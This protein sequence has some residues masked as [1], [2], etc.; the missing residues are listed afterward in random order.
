MVMEAIIWN[1][2]P[3]GRPLLS[4]AVAVTVYGPSWNFKCAAAAY[5]GLKLL[6]ELS[7]IIFEPV[8][9]R[10]STWMARLLSD[11]HGA[12]I[13]AVWLP[14][15]VPSLLVLCWEVL[16]LVRLRFCSPGRVVLLRQNICFHGFMVIIQHSHLHNYH[17]LPSSS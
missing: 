12:L 11:A 4:L 2:Q 8:R 13:L 7:C 16:S 10:L 9:P 14:C 17:H 3:L 5:A 15:A 6:S 1:V